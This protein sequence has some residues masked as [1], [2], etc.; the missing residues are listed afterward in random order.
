MARAWSRRRAICGASCAEQHPIRRGLS[1]PMCGRYT[2][3]NERDV[4][5]ELEA[6]LDPSTPNDEW[7]KPRFNIAP[8][9]RAPVVTLREG[10]RVVEMMRWGLLPFWTAR[11]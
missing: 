5:R 4:A 8:T 9:Q 10:A 1:S 2:L 11:G 6:A 3:T 7:W